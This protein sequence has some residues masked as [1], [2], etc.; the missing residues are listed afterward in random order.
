MGFRTCNAIGRVTSGKPTQEKLRQT[1]SGYFGNN[2]EKE[3][4]S[5]PQGLHGALQHKMGPDGMAM[6]CSQKTMC[7]H[8]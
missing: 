3:P 5:K 8:V 6:K 1:I 4:M 2:V 7:I